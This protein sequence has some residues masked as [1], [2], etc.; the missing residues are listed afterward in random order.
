MTPQYSCGGLKV[1]E[2]MNSIGKRLLHLQFAYP[3][4]TLVFGYD[5]LAC[6]TTRG[7]WRKLPLSLRT[8][9]LMCRE[10]W[11][12]HTWTLETCLLSKPVG[13]QRVVSVLFCLFCVCI[14]QRWRLA[15]VCTGTGEDNSQELVLCFI[16]RVSWGL[17]LGSQTRWQVFLPT[18]PSFWLIDFLHETL[19]MYK[20]LKPLNISV[21]FLCHISVSHPTNSS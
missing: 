1:D 5:M 3:V 20:I 16:P 14:S 13:F 12:A 2:I 10:T 19:K 9:S 7:D 4:E 15:T 18:K 8:V 6:M 11:R 21:L 17:I